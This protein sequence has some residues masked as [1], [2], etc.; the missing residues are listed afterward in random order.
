MQGYGLEETNGPDRQDHVKPTNGSGVGMEDG[1]LKGSLA[2]L[3]Y[4]VLRLK[5]S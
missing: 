1:K 4:H 2:P 5:V 3:S